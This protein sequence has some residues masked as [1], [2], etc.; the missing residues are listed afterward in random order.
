MQLVLGID[1]SFQPCELTLSHV[2]GTQIEVVERVTARLDLF[3]SPDLL[4]IPEM[5]S[6]TR[7][8]RSRAVGA[9]PL[10]AEARARGSAG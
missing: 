9:E 3:A 2:E 7:K 6:G 10:Q 8:S 4:K 1:L 5:V